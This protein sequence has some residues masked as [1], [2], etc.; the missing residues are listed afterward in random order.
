MV[1]FNP[2]SL[3]GDGKNLRRDT[4]LRI[5]REVCEPIGINTF[6]VN[7]FDFATPVPD[8]LFT[9]WPKRDSR[10]LVFAKL[11]DMKFSAIIR[12]YGD[13]ENRGER[14][15]EIKERILLVSFIF[16]NIEEIAL[17]KNASGTPKHPMSWQRQMLKPEISML[18][19]KGIG[20]N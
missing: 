7:L 18:L 9:N 2:G 1:M 8:E 5:L 17:P 10:D 15:T 11:R 4:T 16:S 13:Y 14:D 19:K 12:A 6:V 3:S 20:L